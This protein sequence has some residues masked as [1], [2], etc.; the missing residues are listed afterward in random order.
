MPKL[1]I[2][3]WNDV[4]R[5]TPQ[6]ISPAGDTIDVTQFAVLIENIRRRWR[7]RSDGARDGLSLFS[8]D[9]F[10]P[11]V[12]ST[13]TRGSHMV[14][15]MNELAPDVA[16]TGNHDFDFGYPHLS[17]LV[18]DMKFPWIL[19]NII[20][21]N[22]N[23]VP[24]HL[25]QFKILVR[26]GI[27]VGIIGLVEE[28]WISTVSS[29]PPNF[30][31][32]DMAETGRELSQLLRGEHRC[33]L[34]IALTHARPQDI[35]LAKDLFAS[36]PTAQKSHPIVDE[37]GVDILLG[38]HDHLY[39]A[40]QGVTSWEGYDISEPSIGSEGDHGDVLVVKSGTNF[41][42]LSELTLELGNTP[43][44]SI[45]R[46]VIKAIHGK[47]HTIK[48]GMPSSKK[49]QKILKS[50]LS[51]VSDTLTAP[52]CITDVE[53]DL[54][55][56]FLRTG[57]MA[58]GNWFADV[59]RHAYD[60]A[61]Y[62][63][64]GS[65]SD[66]VL[67]CGGTLRGD[68]VYPPGRHFLE[69]TLG[70]ILEI[71][72]FEDPTVVLE[73]DGEALWDAL[74]AGL[75][76]YPA[77]EG[78]FPI[79]SGFRVSWDSS[80]PAGQRVLGIWLLQE[81]PSRSSESS[82]TISRTGTPVLVDGEAIQRDKTGR[83]YKIVT[84]D[85]LARGHDG[86]TPL[87]GHDYLIDDENGQLLSSLVR[88]YLLGSRYVNRIVRLRDEKKETEHLHMDTDDI[89]KREID[90]R[91]RHAVPNVAQKWQHAGANILQK[92]R[93]RAHYMGHINVTEREHMSGVDCFN[94]KKVRHGENG[95]EDSHSDDL[96]VIHPVVDGRFKDVARN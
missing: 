71:L 4:Y 1:S 10:S 63:K 33:D 79:V 38:G 8:G 92:L 57:E 83:M 25:H 75:S 13:V 81:A 96:P 89:V 46:K 21:E 62:T 42:D 37:H 32:R 86:Y 87:L 56:Q 76:K 60:D 16:L 65:G 50:V 29:W 45:R 67:I 73:L 11:S 44:R 47:R 91:K 59:L 6:K 40:S 61:L 7:V 54:R 85:Y 43:P 58:A 30:K 53:L 70:N 39:F 14:P 28:D 31:F 95:H 17:K 72:P 26:S 88:K 20:D 66:G 3:H 48:P 22:T 15:V 51:S 35:Q 94:G 77:Q 80:R 27:R 19:S 74:E 2:V 18:E 24:D 84:R 93:S 64:Y 23:N 82:S 49:L 69:I 55:S 12:E 78:R 9:L 34:I 36:S 5:V 52:V 90:H 41:R 68:T